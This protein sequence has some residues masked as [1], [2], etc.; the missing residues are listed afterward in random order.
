MSQSAEHVVLLP[1]GLGMYIDI[2]RERHPGMDEVWL[3]GKPSN[4]SGGKE[5]LW[6]LLTF[7][8]EAV[9]ESLRADGS[10]HRCDVQL[11]VVTDGDRYAS[12][13]GEGQSGTLTSLQWR[14]GG[15]DSAAYVRHP[16]GAGVAMRV[17]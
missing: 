13:W 17:R 2:A 6:T 7:G 15:A 1:E 10:L 12:A 8:N 16:D 9:L 5:G 14:R 11:L 3:L 4:H